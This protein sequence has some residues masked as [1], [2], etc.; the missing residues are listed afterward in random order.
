MT[1]SA[2]AKTSWRQRIAATWPYA[3]A[4]TSILFASCVLF[5][6]FVAWQAGANGFFSYVLAAA[7][8]A[9]AAIVMLVVCLLRSDVFSGRRF[10][11]PHIVSLPTL[12][13]VIVFGIKS[14]SSNSESGIRRIEGAERFDLIWLD[15]RVALQAWVALVVVMAVAGALFGEKDGVN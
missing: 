7:D 9:V 11:L 13:V 5:G 14:L 1:V 4:I 3:T 15:Y 6:W 12:Y 8:P 2:P 10:R